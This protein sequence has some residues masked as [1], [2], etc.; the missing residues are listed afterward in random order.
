MEV[1]RCRAGTDCSRRAVTRGSRSEREKCRQFRCRQTLLLV[2]FDAVSIGL[3]GLF[4]CSQLRMTP[5]DSFLVGLRR[6]VA[7]GTRNDKSSGWLA[8]AIFAPAACRK[9][10]FSSLNRQETPPKSRRG[11]SQWGGPPVAKAN[12]HKRALKRPSEGWW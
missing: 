10:E 3:F 4:D 7:D 11:T 1:H 8:P 2:P 12:T 9:Y 6:Q 5:A